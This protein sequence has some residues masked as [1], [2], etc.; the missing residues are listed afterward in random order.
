[1]ILGLIW[2]NWL[3]IPLISLLFPSFRAEG[4]F[5]IAALF[6]LFC[7]VYPPLG[8][9]SRPLNPFFV[10]KLNLFF[11]DT[12]GATLPCSQCVFHEAWWCPR[13]C[14]WVNAGSKLSQLYI[15]SICTFLSFECIHLPCFWLTCYYYHVFES[16]YILYYLY[17]AATHLSFYLY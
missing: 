8:M 4:L 2:R 17:T 16:I 13:G 14:C 7:S 6:W 11:T 1:M 10:R 15:H 3:Q 9:L 12:T 5:R